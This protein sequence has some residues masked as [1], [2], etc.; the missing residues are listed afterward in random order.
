MNTDKFSLKKMNE[1]SVAVA[2]ENVHV[3][4]FSVLL[5]ILIQYIAMLLQT[6]TRSDN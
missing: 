6:F 5:I 4:K 3:E 2:D 1:Y